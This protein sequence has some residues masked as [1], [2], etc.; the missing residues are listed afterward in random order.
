MRTVT[1]LLLCCFGFLFVFTVHPANADCG[2]PLHEVTGSIEFKR[3]SWQVDRA[4][5]R[6]PPPDDVSAG[7]TDFETSTD[8]ILAGHLLGRQVQHL[9][10]SAERRQTFDCLHDAAILAF[11][12]VSVQGFNP[13]ELEDKFKRAM[14]GALTDVE[15]LE[16]VTIENNTED[17]PS[18]FGADWRGSWQVEARSLSVHNFEL[19]ARIVFDED[20]AGL[21]ATLTGEGDELKLPATVIGDAVGFEHWLD[22]QHRYV[23]TLLNEQDRCSGGIETH[24]AQGVLEWEI[25]SCARQ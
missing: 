5:G 13:A 23:W 24:H 11:A 22:D 17:Y 16:I 1:R 25:T 9:G 4:S 3:L 6:Y 19:S 14:F 7:D 8:A 15:S 20:V 2:K 12:L 21:T 10:E 18:I